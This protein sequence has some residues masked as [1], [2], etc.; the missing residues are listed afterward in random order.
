MTGNFE[1]FYKI[2]KMKKDFFF[3]YREKFWGGGD[4]IYFNEFFLF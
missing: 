2:G 4:F 1:S 3:F